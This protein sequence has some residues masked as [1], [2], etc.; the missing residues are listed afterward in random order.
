M[1]YGKDKLDKKD[2]PVLRCFYIAI[3]NLFFFGESR[4]FY[5]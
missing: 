4:S 5:G 2:L 1:G 3:K